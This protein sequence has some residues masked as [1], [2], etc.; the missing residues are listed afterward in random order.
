METIKRR[1]WSIK[2]LP[3]EGWDNYYVTNTGEIWSRVG[4]NRLRS[5][6]GCVA[7]KGYH[8]VGLSRN[9]REKKLLMT[10]RLVAETFIPNPENK[11]QVNHINGIKTDNRVENLEWCTAKENLAH[12]YKTG[13]KQ[14]IS[15]E[16]RL[17]SY[18]ISRKKVE[19]LDKSNKVIRQFDS[20]SEAANFTN[21]SRQ[22]IGQVCLNKKQSAGGYKWR[23][24]DDS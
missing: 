14:P 17:K 21:I 13:L 2:A 9:Y 12:A 18:V 8:Y 4:K 1:E 22:N 15:D 7:G 23:Y 19:Q 16:N 6:K 11:P 10:H 3:I 24:V 5:L 20:V